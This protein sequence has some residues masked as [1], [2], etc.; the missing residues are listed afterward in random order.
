MENAFK[1]LNED[2]I[3]PKE[4]KD[5]VMWY[6][7]NI[8]LLGLLTNHFTVNLSQSFFNFFPK[9]DVTDEDKDRPNKD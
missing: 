7:D 6:A 2:A 1:D 5:E 8:K 9:K 4:I 3:A